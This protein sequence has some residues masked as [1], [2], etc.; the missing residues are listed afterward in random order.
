MKGLNVPKFV[1]VSVCE[2][3]IWQILHDSLSRGVH[4]I[5]SIAVIWLCKF[6]FGGESSPGY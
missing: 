6:V 2:H 5:K 4:E 1:A 3:K